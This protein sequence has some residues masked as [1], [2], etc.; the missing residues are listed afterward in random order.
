NS[1]TSAVL[2]VDNTNFTTGTVY[3][4]LALGTN[5]SANFLYATNFRTGQIDVYN[6]AFAKQTLGTGSFPGTFT[7]PSVPSTFAPFG[8]ANLGGQLF[9]T[10]ALQNG[11]K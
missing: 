5:S 8:I 7:D 9:V 6:N 1:G 4:G 2:K 10:Y 11:A 3:K